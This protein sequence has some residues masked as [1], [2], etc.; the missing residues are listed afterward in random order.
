MGTVIVT[1]VIAIIRMTD[2]IGTGTMVTP[3]VHA[4]LT[5]IMTKR[6]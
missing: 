2:I 3:M 5:G 6:L 4:T 1:G